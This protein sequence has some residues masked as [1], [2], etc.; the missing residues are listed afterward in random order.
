[1]CHGIPVTVVEGADGPTSESLGC[2]FAT[3]T[4]S[5]GVVVASCGAQVV[6]ESSTKTPFTNLQ[7][8][9]TPVPVQVSKSSGA[10][11]LRM[12]LG[13]VAVSALAIAGTA[14]AMLVRA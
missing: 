8:T 10:G 4:A 14:G 5:S 7:V 1:M 11:S 12:S 6:D 3:S 13:G 2:A 9:L